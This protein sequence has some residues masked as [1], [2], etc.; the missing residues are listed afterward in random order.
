MLFAPHNS[1]A[2]FLI[3]SYNLF[4]LIYFFLCETIRGGEYI[5]QNSIM[6]KKHR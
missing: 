1:H 2:D 5:I 3:L 6:Q 4:D